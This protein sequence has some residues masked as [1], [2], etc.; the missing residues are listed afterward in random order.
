MPAEPNSIK[1]LFKMIWWKNFIPSVE[2]IVFWIIKLLLVKWSKL[3]FLGR[4][5]HIFYPVTKKH[6]QYYLV[7][8]YFCYLSH[9]CFYANAMCYI[10]NNTMPQWV[11]GGK[12][13]FPEFISY[14]TKMNYFNFYLCIMWFLKIFLQNIF[15]HL[16]VNT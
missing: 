10:H 13:L 16:F 2:T 14:F 7:S 5:L 15:L 4:H 3:Y 9:K 8:L 11:K 12:T 1:T 6:N